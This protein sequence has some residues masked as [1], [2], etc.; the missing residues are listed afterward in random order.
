MGERALLTRFARAAR[1]APSALVGPGDDAAVIAPGATVLSVDTA[2]QGRHFRVE[3]S[4]PAQIGSRA[5]TAA[6]A[7]IAAMG[8]RP[9]GV[10]VSLAA[11][12]SAPVA[13]VEGINTGV[14]ERAAALG[15]AVL[16]GDLVEAGEIAVS[17]T[18][19]GVLDDEPPILL[20][21]ARPGDVLAVSGPLG[22][23]AAGYALISG[24]SEITGDAADEVLAAFRSPAPDLTQ[25]P[26]AARHG[27]SALTDVSDGLVEELRLMSAASGVVV[28]V[29]S[30][31][32]PITEA[33][34][35][36]ARALGADVVSW[37]LTGGEDH[38][39]LGAFADR[40]SV[41]PGWTVIGGVSGPVGDVD[42]AADAV[43]IDG[44][45][46]TVHGW[47]SL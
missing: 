33:T 43:R 38:E 25:G 11:P 36:V 41:P 39:L 30:A 27:A 5:V 40:G 31:A 8:A 42:K 29:D 10:L 4:S 46:A 21:G 47:H 34:R 15:A 24:D 3:W 22:A 45:P 19:V 44:E 23:S 28:D 1:A 20:S 2:V 13:L 14:V 7:D 12:V 17:I 32:V 26:V 18:A 37:A 35:R 16:G 9:T 6:A